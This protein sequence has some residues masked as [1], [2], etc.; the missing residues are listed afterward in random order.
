MTIVALIPKEFDHSIEIPGESHVTILYFGDADL[1]PDYMTDLIEAASKTVKNYELPSQMDVLGFD[2]FGDSD[3]QT[4]VLLLNDEDS[5]LDGF[6]NDILNNCS[7]ELLEIFKQEET[8]PDYKPHIT[9]DH[10][11]ESI[12]EFVEFDRIE[13]WNENERFLISDD[14][15]HYGTPRKSGRYPWGS[16]DNP[17]QSSLGFRAQVAELKAQ[18]LTQKEIALAMGLKSTTELRA[19]M[20]ISSN[21]IRKEEAAK[22]LKLKDKGYSVSAIA[23]AMGKNESSIRSLLDPA[24]AE[25]KNVAVATA[26]ILK[27]DLLKRGYLDVGTGTEAH[28][29]VSKQMLNTS[30]AALQEEG[31]TIHY[32][33]VP[34]LGTG[35]LTTVKVLAPPGTTYSEVFKNQDKIG[36]VAHYTEG[37]GPPLGLEKPVSISSDRVAVKYGPDG[38]SDMDGVIL[39]RP[40][41]GDIS[42]GNAH[43]AQ[44][45]MAVDDSHFLK[46]MAMYSNDLP[47]GVDVMFNTNKSDTGNKHDAMKPM[48]TDKDGNIDWDNPFGASIKT[49]DSLV[50]AQR[51]YVDDKGEKKLSKLNVVNE[52]GDWGNWSKSIS[53]QVLSKQSPNLAEKQLGLAMDLKNEEFKEINSLTNPTVKRKLLQSFADGCDADASHLKA[54][55]LPRQRTQVILPVPGMK[56]G[57]VYAPNFNNGEQVA[58]IRYPHGGT[59]EIPILKVNNKNKT[60]KSLF[61]TDARDVAG[62][63][64]KVADRLSGADFDGDSV[65]VIPTNG[66]TIRSTDPLKGLAGFDPKTSYK[67]PPGSPKLS[68]ERKQTLMGDVSNLITDMTIM[69]ANSDEVAR[70]VRHSMVVIDAEKHDLNY[71]KSYEDNGIAALKKKYQGG[72]RNGASTL[73]SKASSVQYVNDRKPRKASEGGPIDKNTGA[74]VYSETGATTRKPKK[75]SKGNFKLDSSGDILY[76]IKPKKIKSTKMAE[77]SDAR[78]LMSSK[79][80]TQ[81]ENIYATHANKLKALANQA[82]KEYINTPRLKLNSSAKKTYA[83]EVSSL[84][85]KLGV[86]EKNAP[87]ER[88]AQIQANLIVKAKKKANPDMSHDEVSKIGAQALAESRRR[89]GASKKRINITDKEWVAI[90]NGAVSDSVLE[91]ILRNA[92]DDRVK[93][94]ATPRTKQGMSASKIARAKAMINSG[95]TRSEIAEALGVSVSTIYNAVS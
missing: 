54:A 51:H 15:I 28:L 24:I 37:S 25:R 2:I 16:G 93:E 78:T 4:Q 80:G 64:P 79:S 21:T 91:R 34:Q 47:D 27:E 61:G 69:G 38:G 94:L 77:T 68:S 26:D 66:K 14:I 87:L 88:R 60:A 62:I 49:G 72:A 86:A 40:G 30:L 83:T 9:V 29:G 12:P 50:L 19:R 31:Y 11:S 6:R 82:R 20:S 92:D 35:E 81:M 55:A 33:R 8:H 1:T 58:L 76:D 10:I 89:T 59:F 7:S 44:V 65:V 43:Y 46:G 42:L 3:H 53:S 52:E 45:R 71:K 84:K 5:V 70:A 90:Q 13:V 57:E 95:Y 85:A 56:D 36:T 74:K 32:L 41:V 22:A 23:K 63:T 39:L 75:D 48:K 17:Y 18:G 73:I 67:N